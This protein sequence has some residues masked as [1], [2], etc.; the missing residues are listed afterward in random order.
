MKILVLTFYYKPDL[1]AGSFRT[2]AFVDEL[3]KLVDKDTQ[4]E[5]ITTL[6]NRYHSF[7]QKA[8]ASEIVGNVTI[9]RIKLPGHKSGM[10]DQS[11]AFMMYAFEVLRIIRSNDYDLV[12][13]PLGGYSPLF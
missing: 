6:P 4:I 2:T 8:L 7:E 12:L 10:L 13:Q 11:R 1:S 5:V 9:R 3:K